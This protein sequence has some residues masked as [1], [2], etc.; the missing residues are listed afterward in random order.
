MPPRDLNP[1][2]Q[3]EECGSPS[4]QKPYTEIQLYLWIHIAVRLA[5]IV[6]SWHEHV[7]MLLQG[8]GHPTNDVNKKK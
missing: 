8:A 6:I 3:R 1:Y 7:Y 4:V 5:C 2:A